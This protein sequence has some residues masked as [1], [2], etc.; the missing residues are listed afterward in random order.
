M[1]R[2]KI[3]ILTGYKATDKDM[4]CR[5]FKYKLGKEYKEDSASLCR[6]GFHYCENP[7]DILNYYDLCDSRFF[8]IEAKE[9]SPETNEQDSKRVAKRIKLKTELSLKDLITVSFDYINE[10]ATIKSDE[11]NEVINDDGNSSQVAT[12]GNYS[13]VAT[14]GNYSKVATS[15]Y[16]SQVATSGYSSQ[17]ATSGN[18]SKVATSGDSSQV[19]TSGYS[20]QVATSGDSSKVATSGNYSKVATSGDSSQVA[21]SGDSSQVATSGDYSKV[22]IDGDYSV[23]MCAG[24]NSIIK[25]KKGNWITLTEWKFDN[26]LCKY[27]PVCVKSAQIDGKV[28]KEDTYYQL[29]GGEFIEFDI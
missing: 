7:L 24:I 11:E 28:L 27:I 15:G 10:K 9:V 17:V 21:T 2:K 22:A 13:K 23:G 26:N 16:S 29:K 25:G 3:E 5:D 14:S 19:A 1:G 8:K 20:S 18:Y 6:S 4:K 12:S